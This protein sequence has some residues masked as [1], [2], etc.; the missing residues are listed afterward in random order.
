MLTATPTMAAAVDERRAR[1]PP[2]IRRRGRG[3]VTCLWARGAQGALCS[4]TKNLKIKLLSIIPQ[5][6]GDVEW[7]VMEGE[8]LFMQGWVYGGSG[9]PRLFGSSGEGRMRLLV[10]RFS[11]GGIASSRRFSRQN[12]D[13]EGICVTGEEGSRV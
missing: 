8:A 9:G 5:N 2:R 4:H 13:R 12:R 10:M 3:A 7:E 1:M 6:G 11:D